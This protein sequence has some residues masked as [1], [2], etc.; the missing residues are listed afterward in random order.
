LGRRRRG[1]ERGAPRQ[2]GLLTREADRDDV[3][4]VFARAAYVDCT[5]ERECE[6]DEQQAVRLSSIARRC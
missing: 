3:D 4:V 5:E 6:R 2:V 1:V